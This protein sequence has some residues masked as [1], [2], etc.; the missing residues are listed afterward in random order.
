MEL[1]R[2]KQQM[3]KRNHSTLKCIN[4][5]ASRS[6]LCAVYAINNLVLFLCV[7]IACDSDNMC[8]ELLWAEWTNERHRFKAHCTSHRSVPLF[9]NSKYCERSDPPAMPVQC[10]IFGCCYQST[11]HCYDFWY[12]VTFHSSSSM[13]LQPIGYWFFVRTSLSPLNDHFLLVVLPTH[14]VTR[15][16]STFFKNDSIKIVTRC[17]WKE[18]IERSHNEIYPHRSECKERA[19][20]NVVYATRIAHQIDSNH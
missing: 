20:N 9:F 16:V 12:V 2:W 18:L 4:T 7:R 15:A 6:Q 19:S 14:S 1:N 3:K 5:N 13:Y 17:K 10:S 8:S 11:I